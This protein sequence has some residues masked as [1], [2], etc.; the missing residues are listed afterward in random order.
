[1][2]DPDAPGGTWVHWVVYNLPASTASLPEAVQP[3]EQLAGGGLH[4]QN[5]W[6]KTGYGG[7]CPPSGTHH[8][9]FRLYALDARLDLDAGATEKDLAGA[10]EG[11]L[12]ARGQ[13]VGTYQKP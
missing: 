7:P 13:L 6:K 2:D 11:H 4:G 9:V 1:M 3:G 8:Y 10:M 5:S 12:L